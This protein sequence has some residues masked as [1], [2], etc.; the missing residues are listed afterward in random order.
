MEQNMET[1]LATL[2]EK[3]RELEL[4]LSLRDYDIKNLNKD[5]ERLKK[6]NEELKAEIERY[7][8]FSPVKFE[9]I[10]RFGENDA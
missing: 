10:E 9:K 8:K 4:Q 1:I 5:N 3:I 7:K 6:E 2:A